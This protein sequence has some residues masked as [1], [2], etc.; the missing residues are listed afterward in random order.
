MT[1]IRHCS[2]LQFGRGHTI[3]E[4]PQASPDLSTPL[5]IGKIAKRVLLDMSTGKQSRGRPRT[6]SCDWLSDLVWSRL[7]GKT[8]HQSNVTENRNVFRVPA[9]F[10][11][12]LKG[13]VSLKMI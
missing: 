1:S 8:T 7:S 4:S 13:N 2:I 5:A 12:I 9:R 11:V 6:M 10:L 3:K